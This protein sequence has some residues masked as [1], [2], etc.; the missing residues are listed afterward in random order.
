MNK[1]GCY[2]ILDWFIVLGGNFIDI[3]NMYIKGVLEIIIGEWFVKY[4]Y[5][6]IKIV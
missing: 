5:K 1:V 4:V 2:E 3:V 6:N